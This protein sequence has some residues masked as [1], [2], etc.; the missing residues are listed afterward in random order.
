MTTPDKRSMTERDI[1]TKFVVPALEGS[2][3]NIMTQVREEYFFTDGRIMAKGKTVKQ[4]VFC[5]EFKLA[6]GSVD[7]NLRWQP[8]GR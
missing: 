7:C 5:H 1:C 8:W 4:F 2:G 6:A 3:W